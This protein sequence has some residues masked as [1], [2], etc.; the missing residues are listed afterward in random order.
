MDASTPSNVAR[1]T[2]LLHGEPEQLAFLRPRHAGGGHRHG[3]ARQT[4]HLAHHAAGEF[5]A[6]IIAG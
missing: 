2:L 4:V 5:D 3:E 1:N 6:A